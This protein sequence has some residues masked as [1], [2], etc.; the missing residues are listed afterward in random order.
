M[1]AIDL[2]SG[3]GGL[4]LGFQNAGF[5]II[6]AYENWDKAIEIYKKNFEHPIYE[7]D[8]S[9]VEDYNV[10]IK[11]NPDI[12]IGGPP[13][14]DYSSAGKRKEEAN[15]NL[16]T[17]YANIIANVKPKYFLMENVDQIKKYDVYKRAVN[18]FKE[19]GYGLTSRILDA[20]L[21]G[22]PQKRKRFFLFGELGGKDNAFLPFI[23][24]K[25]SK[26]P[27]TPRM[28]F[29][30]SLG[31]EH[32]YRHPRNYNRRG[33]FSIDEPAPTVRGVNR[34]VPDG[35]KGHPRDTEDPRKVRALTTIERSYLQTFP[36]DFIFEGSKTNLEQMIGNA[37]PVKLAEFVANA[38]D[39]YVSSQ[40][41]VV[42]YKR[43]NNTHEV[44]HDQMD[45]FE[46]IGN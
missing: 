37:V 29:G 38:I 26:E 14:Q 35:Y 20:S 36:K 39:Q 30:D 13:C 45:M 22:V 27:M 5:E 32:Y 4:S 21:C 28:Y 31:L 8:L 3:C 34:P 40:G 44:I 33:V 23:E 43:K 46:V 6:S 24:D 41:N 2:F 17:D 19:A 15:A 10:F 11:Q 7:Y 42:E 16:T 1:R 9:N 25:I 12:I 18:I